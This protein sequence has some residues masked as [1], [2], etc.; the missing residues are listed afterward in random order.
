MKAKGVEK[1]LVTGGAGF[2]GSHT[3]DLLIDSGYEVSVLDSLEPQVHGP[4]SK[5]PD[6]LNPKASFV[7][8]DILDSKLVENLIKESDA[9]IH[10]AAIVGVG[11]S[12]YQIERYINANTR[13]TSQLLDLLVNKENHVRKLLVASSMSVYGEGK[14]WCDK[15][16]KEVY[17]EIRTEDQLSKN[18]WEHLCPSCKSVLKPVPTTENKPL[19]PTSIYAMSKRH[20]E[21]AT[22][23]IGLT[24][25]L[26]SVALRYF[27][28]YGSRQSLSNPYTGACAIFSS[29]ILNDSPPFIFEDGKQLRD[30]INV[31]D[32]ARANKLALESSSADGVPI[33]I[34]TGKPASILDV[35]NILLDLYG[36]SGKL[37]PVVSK[38][39]RKGDIRHCYADVERAERLLGFKAGIGLKDGLLELADWAKSHGW[40]AVDLF[41]KSLQELKQKRLST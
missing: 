27:N 16:S 9:V 19:A 31:R 34:G 14:Y 36:K 7:K 37:K 12:M 35:S 25:G 32:I 20:Q 23:L 2:I 15:C 39:Y 21:E 6:Y 24:Y 28:A 13:G 30:F 4:N 41:E 10:L 33:N 8:G 1:V 40:G 17:P 26:S 29:R 5:P 38:H 3:V 22:L 11:Q 18:I